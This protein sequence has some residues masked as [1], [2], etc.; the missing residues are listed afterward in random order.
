[1]LV[2]IRL[3]ALTLTGLTLGMSFAHVLEMPAKLA[4]PPDLYVALQNSL[5]VSFGPPNVGAFV[6]PGAIVAVVILAYLVRRRRTGFWLTAVAALCLLLA[7]PVVFF[8]FTDPANSVFHAA[9][10][11]SVPADF[12]RY[13]DQWEYSHAARFVLHLAGF[14][15]LALSVLRR[16]RASRGEL[17]PYTM[18]V[19]R[20]D[21]PR[22][23]SPSS[24]L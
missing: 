23:Y 21:R 12:A 8:L 22:S 7:F 14:M 20:T 10:P 17:S 4:Y 5:Y 13:R 15:L 11:A 16:P 19:I 3:A 9:R 1:M 6:E 24:P 2:G 18:G